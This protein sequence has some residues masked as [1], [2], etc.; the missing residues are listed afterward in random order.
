MF[1]WEDVANRVSYQWANCA[2][3]QVL[4][5]HE[6]RE[7]H[8]SCALLDLCLGHGCGHELT[9]DTAI[10]TQAQIGNGEANSDVGDRAEET[11]VPSHR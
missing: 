3:I 9:R 7:V 4:Q 2:T 1:A 10:A 8:R 11:A 6:Q 5:P